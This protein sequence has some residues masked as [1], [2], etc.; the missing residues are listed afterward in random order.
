MRLILCCG[1]GI[2]LFGIYLHRI[3]L[4]EVGCT[5]VGMVHCEVYKVLID[6]IPLVESLHLHKSVIK[7]GI[8]VLVR[9]RS[10]E[11]VTYIHTSF[12]VFQLESKIFT[13]LYR[14]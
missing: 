2:Y 9:V 7:T 3:N 8:C 12:V 14:Y 5:E 10:T 6:Y 13:Q 11:L 4:F 1:V